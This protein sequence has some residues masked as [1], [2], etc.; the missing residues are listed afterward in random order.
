MGYQELVLIKAA[1]ASTRPPAGALGSA[2]LHALGA[3]LVLSH[4]GPPLG[5]S[6]GRRDR[7][8]TPSP[9]KTERSEVGEA[10][11]QVQA[12]VY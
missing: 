9:A 6:R 4:A 8:P 12:A 7:P 2:L 3:R 5:E 1:R 10:R 11:G